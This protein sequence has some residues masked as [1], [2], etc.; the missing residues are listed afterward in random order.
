MTGD[1]TIANIGDYDCS[2]WATGVNLR[3]DGHTLTVKGSDN[4]AGFAFRETR[5][6]NGEVGNL[7]QESGRLCYRAYN[8][9]FSSTAYHYINGD[10]HLDLCDQFGGLCYRKL[11][12]DSTGVN[13]WTSTRSPTKNVWSAPIELKQDMTLLGTAV[14]SGTISGEGGLVFKGGALPNTACVELQAANTFK[15]ALTAENTTLKLSANALSSSQSA[16]VATDTKVELLSDAAS[17]FPPATITVSEDRTASVTGGAGSWAT[18]L[19]KRGEG[20]LDY[21]S[22]I[23]AE[24]LVLKGGAMKLRS[25][26]VLE[27]PAA[28]GLVEGYGYYPTAASAYNAAIGR[29]VFRDTIVSALELG[30]CEVYYG[31]TE[32]KKC[33]SWFP[34][35]SGGWYDRN[36]N[37]TGTKAYWVLTYTGYIWNHSDEAVTWSFGGNFCGQ[38]LLYI[39]DTLV[40]K[41]TSTSNT[42]HGNVTL[43]PGANPFYF[44]VAYVVWDGGAGGNDQN[45]GGVGIRYDPQG[46]NTGYGRDYL[47]LA[48]TPGELPLLTWVKDSSLVEYPRG[49]RFFNYGEYNASYAKIAEIGPAAGCYVATASFRNLQSAFGAQLDLDDTSM[50]LFTLTGVPEVLSD[51]CMFRVTDTWT[52]DA[53]ALPIGGLTS[54]PLHVD[55]L[56]FGE[57][58]E[59]VISNPEATPAGR[60]WTL[61]LSDT[62][63][64]GNLSLRSEDPA[65]R[66]NW[67]LVVDDNSV[68]LKRI[69]LGM[70]I[71]VK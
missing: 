44:S 15:G 49:G 71:I 17:T 46:R 23:G 21:A 2:T 14:L 26:S 29:E 34:E 7:V 45:W 5:L 42:Q 35:I 28:F 43:Q 53:N 60:S 13:D 19:E 27:N 65:V 39:G 56:Q 22:S 67:Q 30:K 41:G 64:V 70:V 16:F 33:L 4:G 24:T 52:V 38:T 54:A 68:V 66:E 48:N 47:P 1:A 18:K 62:D 55:S 9:V 57:Q 20:T 36:T 61:A 51:N 8:Q 31:T 25:K 10:A 58:T 11:V 12:W 59:L 32:K 69:P 6:T 50:A 40:F 3:M 37:P 63:I